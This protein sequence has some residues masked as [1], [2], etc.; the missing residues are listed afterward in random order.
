MRQVVKH[1]AVVA[2]P[3]TLGDDF[4]LIFEA[5]ADAFRGLSP[6]TLADC[7]CAKVHYAGWR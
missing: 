2:R 3:D 5:F 1:N 7:G 6:V 4:A